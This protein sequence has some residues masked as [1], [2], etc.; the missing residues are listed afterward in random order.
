MKNTKKWEM[1]YLLFVIIS[2]CLAVFLETHVNAQVPDVYQSYGVS[3]KEYQKEEKIVKS[4]GELVIFLTNSISK[5]E[6]YIKV[7]TSSIRI[8]ENEM[9]RFMSQAITKAAGKGISAR[10]Y[11]KNS[12]TLPY[13]YCDTKNGY[14][15]FYEAI[16]DYE[17]QNEKRYLKKRANQLVNGIK[18][19]TDYEKAL[20]IAKWIVNNTKYDKAYR[21]DSAYST[22]KK[23]KGTCLGYTLLF[24][25]LAMEVGL[26]SYVIIGETD[27]ERHAWNLVKIGRRYY[28]LDVCWMDNSFVDY[29]YFLFGTDY[30]NKYRILDKETEIK[31]KKI[32]ISKKGIV[33]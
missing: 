24:Q 16:I 29:D 27:N 31:I 30:C 17:T 28:Y 5:R 13:V 8:K 32:K 10:E 3:E 18:R 4:K 9:D 14:V 19:K 23:G 21:N 22:L 33:K 25:R 6:K 15:L 7:D 11:L 20:Y 1:K 12:T 2:I 26:K